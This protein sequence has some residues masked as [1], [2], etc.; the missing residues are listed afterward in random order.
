M[1]NAV[2]SETNYFLN[3]LLPS[4][5]PKLLSNYVFTPP[6][7]LSYNWKPFFRCHFR[8]KYSHQI[9]PFVSHEFWVFSC[10]ELTWTPSTQ[11]RNV[12][13]ETII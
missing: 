3:N 10:K 5:I 6:V 1:L 7:V 8:E 9:M 12:I 2:W 11:H 4:K 13:T